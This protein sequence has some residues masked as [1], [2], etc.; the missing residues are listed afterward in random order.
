MA[1]GWFTEIAALRPGEVAKRARILSRDYGEIAGLLAKA[2]DKE[3]GARAKAGILR[4]LK[5]REDKA[6]A[7]VEE[8]SALLD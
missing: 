4:D 7:Q 1:S 8:L 5:T 6:I 2:G 3:L